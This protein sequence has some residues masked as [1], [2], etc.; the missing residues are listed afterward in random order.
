MSLR[1][2]PNYIVAEL[3]ECSLSAHWPA[4]ATGSDTT[5]AAIIHKAAAIVSLDRRRWGQGHR[6][7]PASAVLRSGELVRRYVSGAVA[8]AASS[9][10]ERTCS[11]RSALQLLQVLVILHL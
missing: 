7:P 4:S 1:E 9:L 11:P 3:P 6:S 10:R 8:T 2:T 5:G